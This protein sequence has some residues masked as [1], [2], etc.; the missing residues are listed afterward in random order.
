MNH[1]VGSRHPSEEL[2]WHAWG[3]TS[4][5]VGMGWLVWW[6]AIANRDRGCAQ[7]KDVLVRRVGC[8]SIP[9]SLTH[10]TLDGIPKSGSWRLHHSIPAH[11]RG[12]ESDS[13]RMR[14]PRAT[15]LKNQKSNT[16]PPKM[17]V[18]CFTHL[19][20][21]AMKLIFSVLS[22]LPIPPLC[23]MEPDWVSALRP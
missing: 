12:R 8:A 4:V 11:A 18:S 16:P 1:P 17:I 20:L 13:Q 21:G 5:M 15:P 10:K 2:A 6:H 3:N 23:I 22:S 9:S 7:A 14:I 19:D